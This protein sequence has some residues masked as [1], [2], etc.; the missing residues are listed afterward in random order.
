M[1][2]RVAHSCYRWLPLT[3]GWIYRQVQC[4]P[5]DQIESHII[6]E[7]VENLPQFAWPHIHA[8]A[9]YN[10]LYNFD[11]LRRKMGWQHH[12]THTAQAIHRYGVQLVHSHFGNKGWLD[13]GAVRGTA[14]KHMV[15]FYG[16]DASKL[17]QQ[18][19]IW[20]TRYH[21]LFAHTDQILCEGAFMRQRLIQL[22]ADPARTRVQHLGVE[23]DQI[24]FQTRHRQPDEPLKILLAAT[25]TEKKGFPDGLEALGRL[26]HEHHIPLQITIIGDARPEPHF[27]A[28]KQKILATLEK[29]K[30]RPFT[31]L[32]GYQPYATLFAEAYQH[33]LFLSP[34]RTARD[35]DAEGGAPVSLIDMQATGMPV[36]STTHCDIPEVVKHGRTGFLSA[37]GDIDGLVQN[38]LHL[39]Q[40]PDQWA[41]IGTA[42]RQHIEQEY[43]AHIQGQRL[44]AIYH[45]L[46]SS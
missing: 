44:A 4:L 6:C 25:F 16:Q 9:P 18:H 26:H 37:E 11:L 45:Q 39:A 32:L 15:T 8:P 46:I 38:L 1:P 3:E 34:S 40:N 29:W 7:R 19:P 23:L 31:R 13:L 10:P 27:Q 42:G 43:N 5:P 22:G 17:P 21:E 2:L 24:R 33:H 36:V 14:A 35:G 30:L 20:R 41:T 28:E 12:L